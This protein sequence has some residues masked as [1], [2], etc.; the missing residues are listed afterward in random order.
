MRLLPLITLLTLSLTSTATSQQDTLQVDFRGVDPS[1]NTPFDA[2]TYLAPDLLFSGIDFGLGAGANGGYSDCFVYHVSPSNGPSTL[3]DAIAE[4]EFL[5]FSLTPTVGSLNLGGQKMILGVQRLNYW[6]PTKYSL[7]SS[8]DGFLEGQELFEIPGLARE[9]YEDA[10]YGFIFPLDGFDGIT[11]P[12]EFRLVAHDAQYNHPTSLTALKIVDGGPVFTLNL[13]QMS[14][15]QVSTF[16]DGDLFEAGT[17]VQIFANPEV[18]HAFAG[19]SG[20]VVGKGNPRTIVMNQDFLIEG[21]FQENSTTHME[22]GM[23]LNSIRDWNTARDFVN[24]MVTARPWLTK[25]E[26]DPSTWDT[27]FGAEMP[28]DENGWPLELPFLASDGGLHYAHNLV[29]L[30]VPGEYTLLVEGSGRIVLRAGLTRQTFYPVGGSSTFSFTVPQSDAGTNLFIELEESLAADPLNN[31]RIIRPGFASTYE[32]DPFDSVYLERL[33]PFGTARFM[34]WSGTN[35]SPV[36]TWAD[37]TKKDFFSQ[38][39]PNGASL[40]YVVDFS[41]ISGQDPWICIPHAADDEYIRE[42]ARLLRDQIS[43]DKKIYVE[44]SNETWNGIF[45]QSAYVQDMGMAL[46]LS[47][48]R[49]RAGQMYHA[50]RSVEIWT[51]FEQEFINDARIV[52]VLATHSANPTTTEV[53]FEA[54]NNADLNPEYVMPDALAIAPYFG[55]NYTPN[56]LPPLVNSYPTVSVLLEDVAVRSIAE[57]EGF[58]RTQKQIAN[59]QGVTLIC[60]EGGQHFTGL[61]SAQ[62]DETL[63]NLLME[64]NGDVRMGTRYLEY[65]DM[66]QREGVSLFVHFSYVGSWGKFGSW[67]TLEYQDQPAA[68]APKYQALLDWMVPVL[69][70]GNLTAGQNA[71]LAINRCTPG[72]TVLWGY[73]L[74]G[75]GPTPS[76]LGDM[77]L[78]APIHSL[79]NGVVDESGNATATK[80]LSAGSSGVSVWFHAFDVASQT[81]SN[82]LDVTIP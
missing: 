42:A 2:T 17:K 36:V 37:H 70:I 30:R 16:P 55:K 57:Q 60:Y 69:T 52:K 61:S 18:G 56:E 29:S 73:S 59:E 76:S 21:E 63:T 12:V 74:T 34:D 64:A 26:S 50:V 5:T 58:V 67:G 9:N 81:F 48:D 3:A 25:L 6:A 20:D 44:Y 78:S 40:D 24:V 41:R 65:L 49:W 43:L 62:N 39:T 7:F 23:N 66:L 10:E 53:R 51:I 77:M 75:A 1:L 35:N 19:W 28:V 79:A 80:L 71:E 31:I 27:G 46:G 68:S 54:L 33:M 15:G 32:T 45:S 4:N 72:G 22:L 13:N 38:A 11:G 14:G 82:G 47:T 8:L